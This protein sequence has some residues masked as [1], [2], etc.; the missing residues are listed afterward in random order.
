M[1]IAPNYLGDGF[2]EGRRVYECQQKILNIITKPIVKLINQ[3][4]FSPIDVAGKLLEF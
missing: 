4:G 3:G 1:I 2:T